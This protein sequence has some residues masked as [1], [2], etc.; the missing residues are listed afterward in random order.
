MAYLV[1]QVENIQF[2]EEETRFLLTGRHSVRDVHCISCEEIL[3]WKYEIAFEEQQKYKEQKYVLEIAFLQQ[4]Y[5][6]P[7][8]D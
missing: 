2:G 3:G 7:V 5:S 8:S 1:E 4:V 6:D